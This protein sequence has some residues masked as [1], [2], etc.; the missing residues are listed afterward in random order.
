ML[1]GGPGPP[2]HVGSPP[3]APGQ[4]RLCAPSPT[5]HP[6]ESDAPVRPR[7]THR[8][9][10]KGTC[11]GAD[12]APRAVRRL[13]VPRV[14]LLSPR[15]AERDTRGPHPA[16]RAPPGRAGSPVGYSTTG[17]RRCP[18]AR[19]G[20]H[21]TSS[22]SEGMV[23]ASG[24]ARPRADRCPRPSLGLFRRGQQARVC[25]Y[26]L[27]V[28]TETTGLYSYS[29]EGLV[30]FSRNLYSV[31]GSRP[32]TTCF[33]AYPLDGRRHVPVTSPALT[34]RDKPRG[35]R[36]ALSVPLGSGLGCRQPPPLSRG[37]RAH[38]GRVA[39]GTSGPAHH[40]P[41]LLRQ[42]ARCRHAAGPRRHPPEKS[43][44]RG[45]YLS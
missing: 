39:S 42:L 17:R 15:P 21:G 20:S 27:V 6:W 1:G 5:Q 11:R 18:V 7:R 41:S 40:V 9:C 45:A 28:D 29:P 2:L 32:S 8:S 26:S 16:E 36:R 23:A 33:V 35:E 22:V 25:A 38:K 24:E 13:S 34:A 44:A 30:T 31:R 3:P 43:S 10:P 12:S 19:P 4:Q 37:G 14:G